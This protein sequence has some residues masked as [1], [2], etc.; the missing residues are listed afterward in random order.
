MADEHELL[1]ETEIPINFTK[2]TSEA[3]EQGSCQKMTTGMVAAAADGD[4]DIPAGV[5]HTEVTAA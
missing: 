1:I 2:S 5:V 4:G 3:M